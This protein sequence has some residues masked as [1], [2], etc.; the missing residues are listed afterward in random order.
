M[1]YPDGMARPTKRVLEADGETKPSGRAT[2]KGTNSKGSSPKSSSSSGRYTPPSSADLYA[3]S[4]I[5]VPIIMFSFFALGLAS[6]ILNYVELL[7]SSPS[8][9]Y[10]VGGLGAIL[11]GIIT[12]TQLR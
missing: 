3:P 11:A 2:P 4:P 9:W 10:M 1:L 5:W 7:P 12:A 6:I 8:G